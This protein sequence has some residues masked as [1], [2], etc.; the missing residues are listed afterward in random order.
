MFAYFRGRLVSVLPEEALVEVAGIGYRLMISATTRR[1]LPDPGSEVLLFSH[2]AV[3]EDAFQLYGFS[4]QE[5]RQLFRLLLLASGVG[6]RLAIAVL[7]GLEVHEVHEAILANA[8]ERLY[9]ISGV[10]KKTAARI[11]LELRDKILKLSPVSGIA[12]KGDV[13]A[14]QLRDDAVNALITLGFPRTSVQKAVASIIEQ[15]SGLTV[16]DVIK[17]ALASIHN[18]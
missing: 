3:R 7:S 17:Y 6:P 2:L 10:G 11:I 4:T 1:R 18:A 9:G 12:V 13:G 15:H 5:E 16:E 14:S 8:P